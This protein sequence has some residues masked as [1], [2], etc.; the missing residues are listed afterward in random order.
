MQLNARGAIEGKKIKEK[1]QGERA[2]GGMRGPEEEWKLRFP[3]WGGGWL[4]RTQAESLSCACCVC[5]VILQCVRGLR[6]WWVFVSGGGVTCGYYLNKC[7]NGKRRRHSPWLGGFSYFPNKHTNKRTLTGW[8]IISKYHVRNRSCSDKAQ[9][10]LTF[11][12]KDGRSLN[13]ALCVL[14][15][16][17]QP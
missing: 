6:F 4:R 11:I 1:R 5:E 15:T 2:K 17:L 7:S 8:C 10:T 16:P 9:L 12:L 3:V 13:R 14:F